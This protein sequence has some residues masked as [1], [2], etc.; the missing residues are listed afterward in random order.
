LK[1]PATNKFLFPVAAMRMLFKAKFMDYFKQALSDK[2]VSP[3]FISTEQAQTLDDLINLLYKTTWVVHIEKPFKTPDNLVKYLARYVH[4][5]AIANYRIV[6][7]SNGNVTFSYKDYAD[8]N[9]QKEMTITAVEFIR[10]F[11]MHIVPSGFMKIR[12][13]GFLS[14]ACKKQKIALL[15][16][17][18]QASGKAL[19]KQDKPNLPDKV[20]IEKPSSVCQQCGCL[21]L[22]KGRKIP[23]V[24]RIVYTRVV[25]D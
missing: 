14:N 5:V 1:L 18:I 11:M 4:R 25:N 20:I 19:K 16:D 8:N 17:K 12:Q 24:Y 6:D 2:I 15:K 9:K 21:T 22:I 7:M 10:R 23:A 13:Y 3:L